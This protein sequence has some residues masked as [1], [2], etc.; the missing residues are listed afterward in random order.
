VNPPAWVMGRRELKLID[1]GELP[2]EGRSL[3]LA[4]MICGIVGTI[5]LVIQALL[6]A[7]VVSYSLV[8]R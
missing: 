5:I 7:W 6:V 4:G 1:S 3:A 2:R 8:G